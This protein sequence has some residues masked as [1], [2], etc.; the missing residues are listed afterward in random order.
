MKTLPKFVNAAAV[1]ALIMAGG[2]ATAGAETVLNVASGGSQNMVDYITDYLGPMFEEQNPGVKVR[3]VGTGPGDAGS[4]KIMEKLQA[5]AD[6]GT[7]TWDIDVIVT[8]QKKTGEMVQA[9]LLSK[10]RDEI[11]TGKLVSRDS[12]KMALGT[13]VDGFVMPMFHSQTAFAYNPDLVKNPP[14]SFDDLKNWAAEHPKAFGYNGIKNGMSGVAFTAAWIYAYGGN[15]E[16]IINGPYDKAA[17]KGWDAAL[18]DLKDFNKYVSFTPGN[19]GTLDMLNRGEIVMG[20]VWVDMFYT[21]QAD[22]RLAPNLKLLLPEPGMPGQP[23]YYAVPAKAENRDLAKKFIELAT[24]PKVQA[25]GIVNRFNWYPG[26]DAA[27]VKDSLDPAVWQKIFADVTPEDLAA[28]GKPFPLGPF[29]AD[30][31]EAYE[32]NVTN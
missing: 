23:Y 10:Y 28:K 4:Q 21:W 26:I 17:E 19:A 9:G 20:P 25:E 27:H 29:F 11:S 13:D 30:M 7:E 32:K 1:A 15:T 6:A 8:N 18:A 3:A 22:G 2:T 31:M 12:A 5:Q 16:Q 24:S 14:K